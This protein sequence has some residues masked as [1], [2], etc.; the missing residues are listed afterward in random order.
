MRVAR[1]SLSVGMAVAAGREVLTV[2]LLK[3]LMLVH[4]QSAPI[5]FEKAVLMR[6]EVDSTGQV[7]VAPQGSLH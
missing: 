3:V 6:M 2:S 1:R 5:K 7:Q 4:Y